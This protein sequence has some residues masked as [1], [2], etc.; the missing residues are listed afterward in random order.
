M[1]RVMFCID[2]MQVG[3][4][5]LN[6]VRTAERLDRT[7]F[8]VSVICLQRDGPLVARY[9]AAGIPVIPLALKNLYG[10]GTVRQ[11]IRLATLLRERRVDV[12]HAHDFYSN[13]FGVPWARVAGTPVV[14]ASRRW[15]AW[16]P[17]R[18]HRILNHVA[19][20]CA[21]RILANSR[22]I[23]EMLHTTERFPRK[24]VVVVPNFVD[25]GSIAVLA[26]PERARLLRALRVPPD[27]RVVGAVAS[28]SPIKNHAT[29]LRA[30]AQLVPR[31]P[32]L[33]VVIVGDGPCRSTLE[34]LARRLDVGAHVHFAG[35]RNDGPQ[36][37]QL[38]EIS[39]LCSLSEGFPNTLIEAMAQGVPVVAT[40]VGGNRDAVVD[41]STG[42]LV[43]A[44][45]PTRLATALDA[46]LRDPA[47][48][49][50]MG[51]AAQR[52]VR[53]QF[54]AEM[55]SPRSSPCT[56]ACWEPHEH[57]HGNRR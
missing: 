50:A 51:V 44:A 28:L 8:D 12:F 1:S 31:W 23:G 53:D 45:D 35:F 46:L 37:H 40:D 56:R 3:G 10:W 6:A 55:P 49:H 30:V 43:P 17:R 52:H 24:Q 11:G 34:E 22:A 7:R 4:T 47:R 13:I 18:A 38:F 26:A 19:S 2:N 32:D 33:H 48:R 15:W 27:A 39:V 16:P 57:Q 54:G 25:D 14:I 21:H 9:E 29:L 36:L 41:A 42:V 20:R 5:E